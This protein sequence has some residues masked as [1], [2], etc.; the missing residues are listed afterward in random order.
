METYHW[1]KRHTK[2]LYIYSVQW[3]KSRESG[4]CRSQYGRWLSC[5]SKTTSQTTRP[6]ASP[7]N[8]LY[9]MTFRAL[10][11]MSLFPVKGLFSQWKLSFPNERS[12]FKV[13]FIE[14]IKRRGL[15][16]CRPQYVR[17]VLFMGM[18]AVI[19]V[20]R[21]VY[22]FER[23]VK[24]H[25][26]SFF[27]TFPPPHTRYCRWLSRPFGSKRDLQKRCVTAWCALMNILHVNTA[28]HCNTLEHATRHC[29][30]CTVLQY[31]AKH[32]NAATGNK[33]A[34]WWIFYSWRTATHCQTLQHAT[35]HCNTLQHTA[36]HCNTL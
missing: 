30:N 31:T 5:H 28:T 12:L 33:F 7:L 35:T 22:T 11:C 15:G 21:C 3:I 19:F 23:D 1:E 29:N 32:C 18:G 13:S 16:A 27:P 6:G 9:T 36:P 20:V 4:V 24:T 8:L 2:E 26:E 17:W 25:W 34:R 14:W 10:F